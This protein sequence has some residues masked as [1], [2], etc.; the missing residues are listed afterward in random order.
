MKRCGREHIH[1]MYIK[2]NLSLH[3]WT[4]WIHLIISHIIKKSPDIFMLWYIL[5]VFILNKSN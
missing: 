2:L 5:I 4:S 3:S 1:P